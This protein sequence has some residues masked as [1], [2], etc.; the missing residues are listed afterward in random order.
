MTMY[1]QEE[2]RLAMELGKNAMLA[3]LRGKNKRV[4]TSQA[5]TSKLNPKG[6]SRIPP[7][8]N[9]QKENKCFLCKKDT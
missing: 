9:I 3:T 8:A 1:A 5:S 2:K 7:Q 6:K 4:D